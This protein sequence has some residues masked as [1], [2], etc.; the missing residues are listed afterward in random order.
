MF[1][2]LIMSLIASVAAYSYLFNPLL[3]DAIQSGTKNVFTNDRVITLIVM[4]ALAGLAFPIT[5]VVL[6]VPDFKE[7]VYNTLSRVIN[8]D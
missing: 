4:S 1:C 6:L 3:T 7:S 8:E 5:L 2:I